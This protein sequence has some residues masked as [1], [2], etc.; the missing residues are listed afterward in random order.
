[1]GYK[2]MFIDY[3]SM[4]SEEIKQHEQLRLSKL[5]EENPVE[6][7]Q[8]LEK[9]EER[10]R[11][12]K[13][14]YKKGIAPEE[15]QLLVRALKEG[16]NPIV[17]YHNKVP[18]TSK[19]A[20][21]IQVPFYEEATKL[22]M[23]VKLTNFLGIHV[24]Q[25][26]NFPCLIIPNNIAS[27]NYDNKGEWRYFTRNKK[28]TEGYVLGIIDIIEIVYNLNY[29]Q[30]IAKLCDMTLIDVEEG[31][32]F[33][34]QRRKYLENIKCIINFKE[35]AKEYPTLLKYI[36][37]HLY[38]LEELNRH[39]LFTITNKEKSINGVDVFFISSRYLVKRLE[40]RG[41]KKSHTNTNKLINMFTVLGFIEEAHFTQV[42]KRL[43]EEATKIRKIKTNEV[44]KN[45]D[46]GKKNC[47]LISFYQI[48]SITP[49]I[50]SE[51]EKRVLRLKQEKIKATGVIIQHEPLKTALGDSLY[52]TL[53]KEKLLFI[54]SI[55]KAKTA[56][57]EAD[58][59]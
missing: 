38:V 15:K 9:I 50:L 36:E 58:K 14:K 8:E 26:N 57:R 19:I 53:F 34:S 30:A 3:N 2:E 39:A 32:W 51:A 52:N 7:Y 54:Q 55:E 6:Y 13:F 16:K 11:Q 46:K 43:Q 31:E 37:K 35:V 18:V 44:V 23:Q 12:Q 24:E 42:P 5:K 22:L 10:L 28:N 21:D 33:K 4:S 29:H 1:M 49:E 47:H 56:Q 25:G 20:F 59:K 41:I 48:P 17:E 40:V 45:N 27:I